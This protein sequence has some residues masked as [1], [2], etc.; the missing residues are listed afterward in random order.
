MSMVDILSTIANTLH[1]SDMG[2]HDGLKT[3]VA[4][5]LIKPVSECGD[6]LPEFLQFSRD[7]NT[8]LASSAKPPSPR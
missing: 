8:V 5:L 4:P 6:T 7:A 1:E 3:N 2:K